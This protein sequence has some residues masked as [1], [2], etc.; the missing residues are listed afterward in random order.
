VLRRR[1]ALKRGVAL[2]SR[3]DLEAVSLR[4][5]HF[6]YSVL[7]VDMTDRENLFRPI[8]KGIRSMIYQLGRRLQT[9][10]FTD[11][12]AARA[13]TKDL[14]ENLEQTANNCIFCLL[15]VHS[16]HEEKDL[17]RPVRALDPDVVGLMMKEH[18]E[19][20]KRIRMLAR[21]CDEVV[22]APSVARRLELGDRLYQE[23]NDLF[24]FYLQHLNNE[25][26]TMVP[27]MW[28]HFTDEQLRRMRNKFHSSL[29]PH[30]LEVWM[31]WTFPAL[32]P[33]ELRVFLRGVKQDGPPQMY[34][35]LARL[36]SE[37]VD[38][39]EWEQVRGSLGL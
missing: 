38:P 18:A 29:P 25:E 10:D 2:T 20:V 5:L 22:A 4:P 11:E 14:R 17:F 32:N 3:S 24:A 36:A 33:N 9:T 7:K 1:L 27:V 19:I 16:R 12:A 6:L 39:V 15:N 37:T 34:Q 21:T 35:D 31:R 13:I 28:E 26:A 30:Q 23:T 8:H